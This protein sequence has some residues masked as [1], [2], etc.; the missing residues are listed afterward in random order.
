MHKKAQGISMETIVVAVI[1]L[2]V[3]AILLLVFTGRINVFGWGIK[4]C[5]GTLQGA[6]KTACVD[7]AQL[8]Y[9]A[10]GTKQGCA[11]GEHYCCST[12][13]AD[14]TPSQKPIYLLLFYLI[15]NGK[16]KEKEQESQG[17]C[18]G[19]SAHLVSGGRGH[20]LWG[21]CPGKQVCGACQ[22]DSHEEQGK[23]HFRAQKKI[24][25]EMPF[26]SSSI[27]ELQGEGARQESNIYMSNLQPQH[28]I[29][30]YKRAGQ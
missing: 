4:Q 28:E 21:F 29:F 25:Q 5:Q 15:I 10:D 30:I 3:L 2:F 6:C 23:T 14:T 26:L 9:S 27:P 24:L 8:Q 12:L 7:S 17:S 22:K 13:T 19:K 20:G 16:N 1:V 18:H 11:S